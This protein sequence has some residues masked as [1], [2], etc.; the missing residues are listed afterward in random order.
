[1]GGRLRA[2]ARAPLHR[3]GPPC[4]GSGATDRVDGDGDGAQVD[5]EQ[6]EQALEGD[7]PED[8]GKGTDP[9]RSRDPERYCDAA[10]TEGLLAVPTR[11][12]VRC[13]GGRSSAGTWTS[14][15]TCTWRCHQSTTMIRP[16]AS[17]TGPGRPQLTRLSPVTRLSPARSWT[18]MVRRASLPSTAR[19]RA[20]GGR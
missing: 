19:A 9:P 8:G 17:V 20:L 15:V 10:R 18:L 12:I 13:R 6:L 4:P 16:A 3:S 14:R 2:D 1:M 5:T 11:N 7:L